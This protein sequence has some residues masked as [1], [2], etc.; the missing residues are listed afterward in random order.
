MLAHTVLSVETDVGSPSPGIVHSNK[1]SIDTIG[2][3]RDITAFT[4]LEVLREDA[5]SV[6]FFI[7]Q[8]WVVVNG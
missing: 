7:L 5:V 1:R 3:R 8:L 4:A 2:R 6:V